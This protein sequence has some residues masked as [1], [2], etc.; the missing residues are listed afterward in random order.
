ME[1]KFRKSSFCPWAACAEVA[2]PEFKSASMCGI[3]A[4]AEAAVS[5]DKV[6]MRQSENP[7][8]VISLSSEEWSAFIAG[9][10][11]GEFDLS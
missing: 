8:V 11:A 1:R 9:V 5:S 6:L 7:D 4:C 2:M 10:K 3:G